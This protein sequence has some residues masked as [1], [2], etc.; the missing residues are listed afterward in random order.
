MTGP[1]G[2]ARI[3]VIECGM[4]VSMRRTA[5]VSGLG[6]FLSTRRA[7]L[8]PADAGVSHE[9]YRRVAGLRREEVAV[10][11]G[12]SVDYYTRLEQGRER[13]PSAQVLEVLS[14][15]LR[16]EPDA[17]DHLY[18]LAGTTP[19]LDGLTT[20]RD[21][22]PELRQL[23]GQLHESPA[24]VLNAALD[25]L[26][27]NE[28][29]EALHSGF[30]L[31]DNSAR[32]CFLDPLGRTFYADWD[33]TAEGAVAAL[34]LA[35]GQAPHDRRLTALVEELSGAS[36]AFC[37]MWR[38][39]TVRAKTNE[40]KHLCHPVVGD[41]ALDYQSFDV[42]GVPGQQLVV[43]SARPASPTAAKLRHLASRAT[44]A[45]ARPRTPTRAE[46]EAPGAEA[47]GAP[48]S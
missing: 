16:L 18:R 39:Q 45:S 27:R 10:L 4:S 31:N 41:L 20:A 11:A 13:R 5:P 7:A 38:S 47:P 14:R 3:V 34:R 44:A 30:A 28:L 43:F 23:L 33:V 19:P 35:A 9:G 37:E 46:D 48:A 36:R 26:A 22:S 42:R 12:V 17:R 1:C 40:R 29:A 8:D 25:I 24:L 32:M 21:V 15:A 6:E 2:V